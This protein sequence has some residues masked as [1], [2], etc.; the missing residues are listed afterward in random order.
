MRTHTIRSRAVRFQT[1]IKFAW[2]RKL[3]DEKYDL[4]S[5]GAKTICLAMLSMLNTLRLV[6]GLCINVNPLFLYFWLSKSGNSSSNSEAVQTTA[7][8]SNLFKWRQITDKLARCTNICEWRN[9]IFF[10]F[11]FF[12]QCRFENFVIVNIFCLALLFHSVGV[13]SKFFFL[14]FFFDLWM[15]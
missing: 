9:N 10:A 7:A 4:D 1:M 14:V 12:F 8:H 6:R 11:L 13:H 15:I 3:G 2:M 5:A